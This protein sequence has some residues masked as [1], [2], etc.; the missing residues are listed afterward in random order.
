MAQSR[1]RFSVRKE[2]YYTLVASLGRTPTRTEYKQELA[3]KKIFVSKRTLINDG[4]YLNFLLEG[5]QYELN[6]PKKDILIQT[7]TN[8][9]PTDIV[10]LDGAILENPK[11]ENKLISEKDEIAQLIDIKQHVGAILGF[12]KGEDDSKRPKEQTTEI[13]QHVGAI[14]ENLTLEIVFPDKDKPKIPYETVKLILEKIPEIGTKVSIIMYLKDHNLV[15]DSVYQIEM[16]RILNNSHVID[17]YTFMKYERVHEKILER[18]H[19]M[20]VKSTLILF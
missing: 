17:K 8:I 12:I 10:Q 5:E 7:D 16:M 9:Q 11:N 4:L 1:K 19:N 2:I 3:K 6:H 20:K 18:Y 13:I 15:Q 14:L